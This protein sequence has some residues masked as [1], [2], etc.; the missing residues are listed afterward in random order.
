MFELTATLPDPS[1]VKV[2]SPFDAVLVK[3]EAVVERVV[4]PSVIV[5]ASIFAL[6]VPAMSNL[7]MSSSELSS[8]CI[9]VSASASLSSS[10]DA[11][12][13]QAPPA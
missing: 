4:V 13:A 9:L 1:G 3:V 7:M 12:L 2:M 6:S 11:R 8:T 10:P 5:A